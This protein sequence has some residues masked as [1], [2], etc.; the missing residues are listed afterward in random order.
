MNAEPIYRVTSAETISGRRVYIIKRRSRWGI[1]REIKRCSRHPSERQAVVVARHLVC[2]AADQ[3]KAAAA[4]P[5]YIHATG[6][7]YKNNEGVY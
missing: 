2:A 6:R 4:A 3:D 7:A 5:V 1:W